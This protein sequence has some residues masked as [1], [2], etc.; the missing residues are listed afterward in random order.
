[1]H[2]NDY[3]AAVKALEHAAAL[4]P[5]LPDINFHIAYACR[6]LGKFEPAEQYLKRQLALDPRHVEALANLGYLEVEQGRYQEAEEN[7][8]R[9]LTLQPDNVAANFDLGRMYFKL[10]DYE[11]AAQYLRHAVELQP[12]HSQAYYQ[13][14]LIYSRTGKSDL[15][16]ATLAEFKKLEA[17]DERV[18]VEQDRLRKMRHASASESAGGGRTTG[19]EAARTAPMR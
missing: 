5:T 19:G 7:L 12:D 10:K 11:R 16:Q 6:V 9:A 13:L 15:A 4:D 17:L 8:G 14:F 1:M 2:A 3:A 18:K